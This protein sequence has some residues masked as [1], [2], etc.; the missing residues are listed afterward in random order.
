MYPIFA[1][2]RQVSYWYVHQGA[3]RNLLRR[4]TKFATIVGYTLVRVG[5][6]WTVDEQLISN[7]CTGEYTYLRNSNS[8]KSI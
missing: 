3:Y 7:C 4:N 8:N 6:M 5:T 1:Q 2:K